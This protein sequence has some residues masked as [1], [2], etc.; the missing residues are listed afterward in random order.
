[1]PAREARRLCDPALL[2]VTGRPLVLALLTALRERRSGCLDGP[3]REARA[4][5]E[6]ASSTIRFRS[7][8]HAVAALRRVRSRSCAPVVVARR[9]TAPALVAL[10]AALRRHAVQ[11]EERKLSRHPHRA[12]LRLPV[13]AVDRSVGPVGR[14]AAQFAGVELRVLFAVRMVILAERW[15]EHRHD[16][17][18]LRRSSPRCRPARLST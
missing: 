6:P 14:S 15:T 18:E 16:L 13:F 7:T 1:M 8:W 12:D 5:V 9:A 3:A 17:A 2:L 10:A 4:A 11:L